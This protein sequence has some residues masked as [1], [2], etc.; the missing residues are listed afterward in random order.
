MPIVF[1]AIT[2][3][4]PVL[5]PEIGKENL[6]KIQNTASAME[7]LEQELYAAR[8]DSIVVISPHGQILEDAFNVNL[9]AD[10]KANFKEFGDFSLELNFKSDYMSIQEIRAS[11]ESQK[12]VPIVLTSSQE[13]DHG[14]SVPLYYLTKHLK[15]IPIIPITYSTL[16]W[17]QHFNFGNFLHGQLSKISKR[18]AIVA[19]GDLSH[20][21]TKDAPG[22]YSKKGEEFDKKLV[23]LIRANKI[24]EIL[25]FDPKLAQEAGECGLRSILILL[26]ILKQMNVVPEILSYE[27]PFGVGYMVANYKFQ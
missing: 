5:L 9:S 8:P 7:K 27:G 13:L 17:E 16:D 15:S 14:F 10:Y 25:K 2:P 20:R 12:Q 1:A 4:P 21:L 22:G 3:H 23:E 26:G 6:A 11:D 19:S 18:F 24:D